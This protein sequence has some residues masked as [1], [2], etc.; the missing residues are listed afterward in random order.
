MSLVRNPVASLVAGAQMN[1]T[2]I[3]SY[4]PDSYSKFLKPFYLLITFL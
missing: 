2:A 3:G 1:A 4:L